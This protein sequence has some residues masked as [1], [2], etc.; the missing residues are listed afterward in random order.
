MRDKV[1]IANP[2]LANSV[3]DASK[4][5]VSGRTRDRTST[6]KVVFDGD[7]ANQGQLDGKPKEL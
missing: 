5:A 6:A 7:G 2:L 4:I 3:Q 1:L